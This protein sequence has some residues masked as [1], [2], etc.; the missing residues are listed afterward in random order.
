MPSKVI[1]TR[2]GPVGLTIFYP[3]CHPLVDAVSDEVNGYF[4]EH[5]GF[6]NERSRR[7]FVAAGF[8]RVTCLYFPRALDDRIH[9]ACRLLTILFLIDG[10]LHPLYYLSSKHKLTVV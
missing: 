5:W 4:L 3:L 6:E 8:P 9:Y 2:G 10:G 1:D 7:K